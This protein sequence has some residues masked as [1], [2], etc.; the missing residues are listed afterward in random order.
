MTTT[1]V[2]HVEK[3]TSGRQTVARRIIGLAM[4]QAAF[5][6]M[7]IAT[8][9]GTSSPIINEKYVTSTMTVTMLTP[10]A[11]GARNGIFSSSRPKEPASDAPENIPVMMLMVVMPTWI[12]EKSSSF[13]SA[14]RSA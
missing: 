6:G 9:F 4:A 13:F 8:H 14:R 12:V 10:C 7:A 3:S 1:F 2:D 5:S 11:Y